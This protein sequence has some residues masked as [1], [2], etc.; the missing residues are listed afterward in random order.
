[1]L[2]FVGLLSNELRQLLR[3]GL[4]RSEAG[5]G[6][7]LTAGE[8]EVGCDA[9]E[10][11]RG[12]LPVSGGATKEVRWRSGGEELLLEECV[13][14]AVGA[15]CRRDG[16]FI[17]LFEMR[18]NVQPGGRWPGVFGEREFLSRERPSLRDT[19]MCAIEKRTRKSDPV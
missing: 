15:L 5:D 18:K 19:S 16:D 6:L 12:A 8:A 2:L 1:M 9:D 7:R 14:P 3:P 13:A 17:R 11:G 4:E 10:D